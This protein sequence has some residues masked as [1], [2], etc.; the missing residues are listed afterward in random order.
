MG[1]INNRIDKKSNEKTKI[2]KT[3]YNCS[4]CGS[5]MDFM[6]SSWLFKCRFCGE[7]QNIDKVK[8]NSKFCLEKMLEK[9]NTSTLYNSDTNKIKKYCSDKFMAYLGD[10]EDENARKYYDMQQSFLELVYKMEKCDKEVEELK[11]KVKSLYVQN[12]ELQTLLDA[13]DYRKKM[14]IKYVICAILYGLIFLICSYFNSTGFGFNLFSFL[15]FLIVLASD[16]NQPR[17]EFISI[18]TARDYSAQIEANYNEIRK[19]N[20]MSEKLAAEKEGFRRIIMHSKKEVIA[21]ENLILSEQTEDFISDAPLATDDDDN[22]NANANANANVNDTVTAKDKEFIDRSKLL[23]ACS[24]CGA[25]TEF[26]ADKWLFRCTFCGTTQ[27]VEVQY[28]DAKFCVR[29]LKE[30]YKA[31]TFAIRRLD[32]LR[33]YSADKLMDYMRYSEDAKANEFYKEFMELKRLVKLFEKRKKELDMKE[34]NL[35]S[36]NRNIKQIEAEIEAYIEKYKIGDTPGV[37]WI[38]VAGVLVLFLLAGEIFS[39]LSVLIGVYSGGVFLKTYILKPRPTK[40]ERADCV[41]NH[42]RKANLEK[43]SIKCARARN[44]LKESIT[45]TDA[46]IGRQVK[47]VASLENEILGLG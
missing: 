45:K 16:Y 12:A 44:E 10:L 47:K 26:I 8:I 27:S 22:I 39:T 36:L 29:H 32:R 23:H 35:A 21:L 38:I 18:S 13:F 17:D 5:A 41:K 42:E 4:N 11:N 7:E 37:G 14:L 20:D 34:E 1:R 30:K 46:Q 6:H 19:L 33:K 40:V 15:Y 25:E 43:E 3:V 2:R 24:N 28:V 31:E 9:Y